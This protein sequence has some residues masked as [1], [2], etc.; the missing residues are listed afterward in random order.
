M[1]SVTA[2]T[3][4][5]TDSLKKILGA[6]NLLAQNEPVTSFL[7]EHHDFS[8]LRTL[9]FERDESDGGELMVI[10]PQNLADWLLIS[11]T[12]SQALAEHYDAGGD[13][14]A[15]SGDGE[16]VEPPYWFVTGKEPGEA[17]PEMAE[18]Q[19]LIS[20][21]AAEAFER[22]QRLTGCENDQRFAELLLLR[23]YWLLEQISRGLTAEYYVP[24]MATS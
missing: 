18:I 6:L 9:T 24:E 15:V 7:V 14:R 17:A 2:L 23:Q 8:P 21:N 19:V 20:E 13:I 10:T 5:L 4:I 11:T 16:I 3:I 22:L 1:G 12:F